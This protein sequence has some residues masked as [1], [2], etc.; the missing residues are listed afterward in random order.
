[1]YSHQNLEASFGRQS[2]AQACVV[3]DFGHGRAR[4]ALSVS[5][6]AQAPVGR[7]SVPRCSARFKT[8]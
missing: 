7:L 2:D 5:L 1:M 4:Q 3:A 8:G 6:C